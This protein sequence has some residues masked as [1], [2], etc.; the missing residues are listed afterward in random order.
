MTASWSP[1]QLKRIDESDELEIASRGADGTLRRF[2]PIWVVSADGQVYVR[3][4]H[5]RTTGWFGHVLESGRA[6]VRVP[7]LEAD[8]AVADVGEGPGG[9]RTSVDEAYRAK[10]G[11]YGSGSVG[12]MVN[13]AAAAATL[14]L[15]PEQ[16]G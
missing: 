6:R 15:T 1:E 13:D 12:P 3:T 7:G 11:R 8:V 4:W 14:R 16:A 10:Y 2:V 5:R 9:L